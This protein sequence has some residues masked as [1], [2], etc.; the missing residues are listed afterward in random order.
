VDIVGRAALML[1]AH[2]TKRMTLVL[3]PD[4]ARVSAAVH[5]AKATSTLVRVIV[6]RRISSPWEVAA[7]LDAA[8]CVDAASEFSPAPAH[9]TTS[10]PLEALIM[11]RLGVPVIS[12]QQSGA[13]ACLGE[14]PGLTFCQRRATLG[15]RA[16]LTI[17]QGQRSACEALM[18]YAASRPGA[19]DLQASIERVAGVQRSAA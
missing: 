19:Q 13:A 6:D 4:A 8:L 16:L 14:F 12:T 9:R 15:S 11:A 7:G 3:H 1:G 5:W 2:A 17:V 10:G 18:A